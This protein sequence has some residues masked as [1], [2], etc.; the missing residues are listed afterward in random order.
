M[1]HIPL[2]LVIAVI[3]SRHFCGWA[4]LRTLIFLPNTFSI[5]ALAIMWYFLL[6]PSLGLVNTA[7]VK[8]GLGSIAK[9]WLAITQT[10]LLTNMLPFLVHVGITVFIFLAHIESI[11]KEYYEAAKLDGA[12]QLQLDLFITIPLLRRALAVN[13]VLNAAFALKMVEYPLIM[14]GGGPAGATYTLSLYMY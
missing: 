11:P 7:L 1:I 3:L 5:A 6:H 4:V 10:A 8:I 12:N 14:T 2:G 9:P 13:C